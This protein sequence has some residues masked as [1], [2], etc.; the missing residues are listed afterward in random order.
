M[1]T[2]DEAI[3][4]FLAQVL[5]AHQEDAEMDE[6]VDDGLDLAELRLRCLEL[7]DARVGP[8]AQ[9][10]ETARAYFDFVMGETDGT[11]R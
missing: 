10:I 7:A 5:T 11:N 8:I 9:V 3:A 6:E 2:E 1:M 4:N